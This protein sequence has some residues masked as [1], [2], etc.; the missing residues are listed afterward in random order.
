MN[1]KQAAALVQG[2]AR[3][4]NAALPRLA[5]ILARHAQGADSFTIAREIGVTPAAVRMAL[6]RHKL[7]QA[8]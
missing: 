6:R 1:T 7:R 8:A 5:H 3:R 4:R 2:N